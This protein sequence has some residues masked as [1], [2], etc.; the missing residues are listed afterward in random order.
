MLGIT[1]AGEG[2]TF[3]MLWTFAGQFGLL[4][5]D[6]TFQKA[7]SAPLPVIRPGSRGSCASRLRRS[8]TR[9]SSPYSARRPSSG[10]QGRLL[11]RRRQPKKR[12]ADA[13]AQFL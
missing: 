9:L 3:M 4:G 8:F 2:I 6:Y 7:V 11:A 13:R 12:R 1:S 10:L 5:S